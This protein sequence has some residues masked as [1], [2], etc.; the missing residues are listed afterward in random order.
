MIWLLQLCTTVNEGRLWSSDG[1]CNFSILSSKLF[2][3]SFCLPDWSHTSK[4][5]WRTFGLDVQRLQQSSE[6]TDFLKHKHTVLLAFLTWLFSLEWP[7][8]HGKCRAESWGAAGTLCSP[9][10]WFPQE[11]WGKS[12]HLSLSVHLYAKCSSTYFSSKILKISWGTVGKEITQ[13]QTK[14]TCGV[15]DGKTERYIC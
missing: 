6:S 12:L 4:Y 2:N 11:A 15:N 3:V 1:H 10:H 7:S 5:L 9:A 13:C 14:Q 8:S